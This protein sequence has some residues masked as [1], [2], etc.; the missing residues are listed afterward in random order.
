MGSGPHS[1]VHAGT[2]VS[3]PENVRR[4]PGLS[5]PHVPHPSAHGVSDGRGGSVHAGIMTEKNFLKVLAGFGIRDDIQ[6]LVIVDV[7]HFRALRNVHGTGAAE[8]ALRILTRRL[9]A[10]AIA[11]GGLMMRLGSDEFAVL[12]P[13]DGCLPNVLDWAKSL[14]AG[15]PVSYRNAK[16]SVSVSAGLALTSAHCKTRSKRSAAHARL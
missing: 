13:S 5:A 7:D 11:H 9:E 10:A 12:V 4:R 1:G 8:C 3:V 16:F 15:F 2:L 6:A 14:A